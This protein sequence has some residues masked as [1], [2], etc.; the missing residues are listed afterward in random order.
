MSNARRGAGLLFATASA[1]CAAQPARVAMPTPPIAVLPPPAPVGAAT[2]KLE[3]RAEQ[4]ALLRGMVRAGTTTLLLDDAPVTVAS[5]GSFV[6]GLDRDAPAN[7]HLAA[8]GSFGRIDM[9]LAI[10]P[11]SWRIERLDRLPKIPVPSA[12]FQRRRAGELAQV[13][14]ARAMTTDA[15]GWRQRF[16]WPA[17]GRISGLFGAQRIYR[18]EPGSYHGGTDIALPVGAP[19]LAPADG[20]VI[21]VASTPFTLEGNLLMIDHGAGLN[22]AFLHLSRIDVKVGDRITQGQTIGAAGATGRA[23]GSHL[24]W[25]LKWKEARLDPLLIAG[26]MSPRP[27]SPDAV[28]EPPADRAPAS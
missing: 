10:A 28:P 21:L 6:I 26:P 23:T 14:A 24:H 22:S 19:V 20:V 11:R 3:G 16:I 8:T 4:G 25:A 2:L 1:A 13:A 12:E 15:V 17:T 5:D 18:G 27:V 9:P 7:Q